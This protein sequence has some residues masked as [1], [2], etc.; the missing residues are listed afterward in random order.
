MLCIFLF[1][2]SKM[3]VEYQLKVK[4]SFSF[5][6]F[7]SFLA[8]K[9]GESRYPYGKSLQIWCLL[10]DFMSNVQG[11]FLFLL[12]NTRDGRDPSLGL[13]EHFFNVASFPKS[14]SIRSKW[15][16]GFDQHFTARRGCVTVGRWRYFFTCCLTLLPVQYIW[17]VISSLG[18]NSFCYLCFTSICQDGI[19]LENI[20]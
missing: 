2:W 19:C 7:A 6:G 12:F 16:N 5:W 9:K 8:K 3:D 4:S 20:K 11:A 10:Q 18:L 13:T 15:H 17:G 1:F 14:T